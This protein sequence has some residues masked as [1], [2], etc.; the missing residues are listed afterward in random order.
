MH[1]LVV[2]FMFYRRH[3]QISTLK[4]HG[5]LASSDWQDR[6]P[7]SPPRQSSSDPDLWL[8]HTT[9][10]II[11]SSFIEYYIRLVV[12]LIKPRKKKKKK[13]TF[14]ATSRLIIWYSLSVSIHP[15]Q[16]DLHT[17]M[18]SQI[19]LKS[20]VG[21]ARLVDVDDLAPLTLGRLKHRIQVLWIVVVV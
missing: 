5:M 3:S 4:P 9:I 19:Y 12:P 13:K 18:P 11:S 1:P 20:S 6:W 8:C 14:L 16:F 21:Q 17:I 10:I 7:R 2:F 15:G